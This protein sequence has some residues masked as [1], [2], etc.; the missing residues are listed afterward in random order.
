MTNQKPVQMIMMNSPNLSTTDARSRG[1]S[2]L[3]N[4]RSTMIMAHQ[5][6]YLSP[7]PPPLDLRKLE[8]VRR[9]SQYK[10]NV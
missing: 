4:K 8:P 3:S 9:T 6:A 5:N 10:V 7:P 2:D 1:I